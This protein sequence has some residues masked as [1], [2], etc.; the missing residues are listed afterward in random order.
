MISRDRTA[1]GARFGELIFPD[2]VQA[3][4]DQVNADV[5]RLNNDIQ[6]SDRTMR[7]EFRNN[8]HVFV[9]EWISFYQRLSGS[10]SARAQTA[11]IDTLKDYQKNKLP[12][13]QG[14]L[15]ALGGNVAGPGVVVRENPDT[16]DPLGLGKITGAIPWIVGGVAIVYFGPAIVKLFGKDR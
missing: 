13:W 3:L 2:A 15:R 7:G 11:N 1:S 9:N 12:A 14:A 8:W 4:A 10:W 16:D 5:T 6:A